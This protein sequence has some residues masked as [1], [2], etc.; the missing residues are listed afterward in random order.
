MFLKRFVPSPYD[1]SK[2]VVEMPRWYVF[3][4]PATTFLYWCFYADG[5]TAKAYVSH[6]YR[7]DRYG[8]VITYGLVAALNVLQGTVVAQMIEEA[9]ATSPIFA[10]YGPKELTLPRVR[11]I[12]NCNTVLQLL[13]TLCCCWIFKHHT[14]DPN[15]EAPNYARRFL[16]ICGVGLLGLTSMCGVPISQP[17]TALFNDGSKS[18]VTGHA[19]RLSGL[20]ALF[21]GLG[22]W[23]DGTLAR[24]GV[25]EALA[26]GTNLHTCVS[27]CSVMSE[28]CLLAETLRF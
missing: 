20:G 22:W 24:W 7:Q 4:V 15:E 13:K 6:V 28:A 23:A 27:F 11:A 2:V 19:F 26:K 8:I 21:Q 17:I 3:C 12:V 18:T 9:P 25:C 16:H 10:G 5:T 14:T 1:K